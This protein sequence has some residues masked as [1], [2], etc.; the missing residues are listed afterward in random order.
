MIRVTVLNADEVAGKFYAAAAAVNADSP[1]WLLEAGNI[2]EE[3]VRLRIL[4][5]GLVRT[6]ALLGSGRVF[7]MTGTSVLVGFGE[8]LDYAPALELGAA[9]HPIPLSP[10]WSH[11]L[12]FFW[13]REGVEF[14]GPMVNHPGNKP[15]AFMRRGAESSLIPVAAMMFERLKTILGGI[16]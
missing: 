5:D 7:G 11:M 10:D 6:G 14:W 1:A 4:T 2:V 16:F 15:Y 3:S 9:P 12:H 13:E 8:G